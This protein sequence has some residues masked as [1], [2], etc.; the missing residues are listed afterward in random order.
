MQDADTKFQRA[1]MKSS[2]PRNPR[3]YEDPLCATANTELFFSKDPDEP[4][5]IKS[6]VDFQH[7]LAKKICG[8]CVHKI[9]CAE[10]GI[11]REVHGV[12]GGMT[13]QERRKAR[14]R[15]GLKD[16]DTVLV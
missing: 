8:G 9:E 16:K 5:Y 10:W 4:G 3:E 12:W 11:F 7:S 6:Q 14:R 15:L 2:S 13:P 1:C